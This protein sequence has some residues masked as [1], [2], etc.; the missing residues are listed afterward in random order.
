[1]SRAK[2]PW[3]CVCVSASN[4]HRVT[5]VDQ[6]V[7]MTWAE[8]L[9]RR[10]G[11]PSNFENGTRPRRVVQPPRA[12]RPPGV[13]DPGAQKRRRAIRGDKR[14]ARGKAPRSRPR[15]LSVRASRLV[16]LRRQGGLGPRIRILND[17]LV[18]RRSRASGGDA[19]GASLRAA[20][21]PNTHLAFGR[22]ESRW[23]G[24]LAGGRHGC[25]LGRVARGRP[26]AASWGV[27]REQLRPWVGRAALAAAVAAV[28]ADAK[29]PQPP[30][31]CA[32]R[33]AER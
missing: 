27:P 28:A 12:P 2:L 25:L 32:G 19:G 31:N 10:N 23:A 26:R 13:L 6:V 21:A 30:G 20:T 3:A 29:A 14:L 16:F 9:Q 5:G 7:R 22:R 8:P 11:A 18:L 17:M 24:D 1:M 4:L 15:L 33:V